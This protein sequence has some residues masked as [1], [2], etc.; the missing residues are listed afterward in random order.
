[1]HHTFRKEVEQLSDYNEETR[2]AG[3][4]FGIP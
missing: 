1:M 2:L 4:T 3:V